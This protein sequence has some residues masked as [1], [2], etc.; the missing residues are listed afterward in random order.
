M[1]QCQV[2]KSNSMQCGNTAFARFAKVPYCLL[3]LNQ[4]MDTEMQTKVPVTLEQ[5]EL[6]DPTDENKARLKKIVEFVNTTITN[7]T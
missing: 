6:T 1:E 7:A 5:F 3:H 4:Q 2:M